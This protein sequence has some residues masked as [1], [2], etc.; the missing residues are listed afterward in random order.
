M[1]KK[2]QWYNTINNASS[3]TIIEIGKD[4]EIKD[5]E[6]FV[7]LFTAFIS[8]D[9][10]PL[11]NTTCEAPCPESYRF[12]Q[13]VGYFGGATDI[14]KYVYGSD[15]N[16][17][18]ITQLSGC[19][20]IGLG[21]FGVRETLGYYSGLHN[22]TV[23]SQISL[24]LPKRTTINGII[25]VKAGKIPYVRK[26]LFKQKPFDEELANTDIKLV[27]TKSFTIDNMLS[28]ILA[29][30]YVEIQ[31]NLVNAQG[32]PKELISNEEMLKLVGL[33]GENKITSP[34]EALSILKGMKEVDLSAV[35]ET[36][37]ADW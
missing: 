14:R 7:P 1:S 22:E 30:A 17:F 29:T 26:C 36:S 32:M 35:E 28:S 18:H 25:L 13:R 12:E 23:R 34:S 8:P 5:S 4:I 11:T 37:T 33:N 6:Q 10:E 27:H 21:I 20:I 3:K 2:L 31:N 19:L 24:D 9:G 15:R 16:K